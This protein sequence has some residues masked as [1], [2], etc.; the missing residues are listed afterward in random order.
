[1][2]RQLSPRK[3]R[4]MAN[5]QNLQKP[6]PKGVSG[7]PKGKPKG[8]P[9]SKTRLIRLLELTENLTNPVTGEIE[10]FSVAEQMDLA[11]IVKA[12]KGDTTAYNAIMDRLEGK[13]G[14]PIDLSVVDRRKEILERYL[15]DDDAGKTEEA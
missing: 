6:W 15:K 1:M 8:I 13:A 14:Q 4:A 5:E 12:R 2:E 10:G 11:Q 9:N 7:N 3:H